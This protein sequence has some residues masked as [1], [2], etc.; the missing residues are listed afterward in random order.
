MTLSE[1]YR[2]LSCSLCSLLHSP[3]T[4]SVLGPNIRLRS[5]GEEEDSIFRRFHKIAKSLSCL[6]VRPCVRPRVRME[7][8]GS[9]WID[10]HEIW[11]LSIFR[12]SV[13]E[14][15]YSLKFDK[16]N[17]YFTWRTV[18]IYDHISL[19]FS[20]KNVSDKSCRENQNSNFIFRTF[21][22]AFAKLRKAN[23]SFVMSVRPS[24]SMQNLGSHRTDFLEIWYL[25]I[26]RKIVEKIQVSLK[27]DKNNGYFTRRPLHIFIISRLFFL[28]MR[29]V[30]DKSCTGD[31]NTHF[32]SNNFFSKIVPFMR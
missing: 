22:G 11:Q 14:I 13:E 27:S 6:S 18:H 32:V 15:K 19:S 17:G 26:F 30:S 7:L 3:V 9:H 5:W 2:S 29:T 24:I 31:P 28:R 21:L 10:F 25:N 1:E 16:N 20:L 12:K 4:S 23:I 8:L